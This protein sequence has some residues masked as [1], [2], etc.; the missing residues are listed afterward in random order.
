VT[1]VK[2]D[3][4]NPLYGVV[5]FVPMP[6][7][8]SVDEPVPP[9]VPCVYPN[10]A[11]DVGVLIGTAQAGAQYTALPPQPTFVGGGGDSG[12]GQRT[13]FE[14]ITIPGAL[15]VAPADVEP[16]PVAAPAAVVVRRVLPVLTASV[17]ARIKLVYGMI[18]VLLL[19]LVGGR[20][21]L[22]ALAAP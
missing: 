11:Y 17:A 22:R 7:T 13:I 3:E 9:V 6:P 10:L 15:V 14:T 8:V 21:A 16:A 18:S 4:P 1:R 20:F 5:P 2:R 12:P 19:A